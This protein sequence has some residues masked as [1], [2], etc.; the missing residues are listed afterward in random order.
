M[1]N[2]VGL[3][4]KSVKVN[5]G[6]E[7]IDGT[8]NDNGIFT[9]KKTLSSPGTITTSALFDGDEDYGAV[10]SESITVNVKY[11]TTLALTGNINVLTTD[12]NTYDI[13]LKHGGS[14]DESLETLDG[15]TVKVLIDGAVAYT[16]TTSEGGHAS[17]QH[18]FTAEAHTIKVMFE[19]DEENWECVSN[20][21]TVNVAK[22]STSLEFTVDKTK[23]I[24]GDDLIFTATL[25]GAAKE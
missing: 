18:Q 11:R 25:K 24:V 3:K 13:V 2:I 23:V 1:S 12:K 4:N 8:T 7:T 5:I 16:L 14:T 9:G 17:F 21:L 22:G 20:E 10:S 15:K 6:T 19:E